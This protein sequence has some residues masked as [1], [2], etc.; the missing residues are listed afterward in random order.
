MSRVQVRPLAPPERLRPPTPVR[1]E[2]AQAAPPIIDNDLANLSDALGTFRTGAMQAFARFDEQQTQQQ[3]NQLELAIAQIGRE[4]DPSLQAAGYRNLMNQ[5]S[6]DGPGGAA[7]R[8]QYASSAAAA[9][10]LD[11]S[12]RISAGEIDLTDPNFDPD[13]FIQGEFATIYGEIGDDPAAIGELNR[14]AQAA[15]QALYDSQQEVIEQRVIQQVQGVAED[16]ITEVL[17]NGLNGFQ[18][19]EDF[20]GAIQEVYDELGPASRGGSL[21]LDYEVL[22]RTLLSVLHRQLQAEDGAESVD[23]ILDVL[24]APRFDHQGN[25]L[26]SLLGTARVASIA[27]RVATDAS[28]LGSVTFRREMIQSLAHADGVEYGKRNISGYDDFTFQ[29]Q[30]TGEQVTISGS[31]RSEAAVNY[32]LALSRQRAQAQGQQF[33]LEEEF[34]LT[35]RRGVDH[36]QFIGG[37]SNA[38]NIAANSEAL[39][40][41]EMQ[42]NIAQA[43]RMYDYLNTRNRAALDAELN[44]DQMNFFDAYLLGVNYQGLTDA[45]ALSQAVR[46]MDPDVRAS[47]P[48]EASREIGAEINRMRQG[49]YGVFGGTEIQN[50]GVI[51]AQAQRLARTY[52]SLGLSPEAAVERAL[53]HVTERGTFVNGNYLFARGITPDMGPVIEEMLGEV[54]QQYPAQM[55]ALG[56]E[57]ASQL[58]LYRAPGTGLFG[59]TTADGRMLSVTVGTQPLMMELGDIA[60]RIET[61]EAQAAAER[62]TTMMDS[63]RQRYER[64]MEDLRNRTEHERRGERRDTTTGV[65]AGQLFD[66]ISLS[67]EEFEERELQIQQQNSDMFNPPQVPSQP[68]TPTTRGRRRR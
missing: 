11:I 46:V 49:G 41:P 57:D 20:M 40:N 1:A 48:P 19:A 64:N 15:R 21:N 22:D 68:S 33:N 29:D 26:P 54:F 44:D 36:P 52:T 50:P 24:A 4:T 5:H 38:Y 18:R 55:S 65:T 12:E 42:A 25:L 45:Q 59:V 32:A 31:D 35:I 9:L 2:M 6:P 60:T 14:R 61:R 28:E 27:A 17:Q 7:I 34:N 37:I 3:E 23:F 16:R 56:I 30:Y 66:S 51:T 8:R 62:Q 43:A 63:I 13:A 53:Q 67:D 39:S 10:G 58:A 47:L